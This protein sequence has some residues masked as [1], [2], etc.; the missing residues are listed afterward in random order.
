M[1]F[2][3]S[4]TLFRVAHAGCNAKKAFYLCV[5]STVFAMAF[6]IPYRSTAI[7]NNRYSAAST[8]RGSR[9]GLRMMGRMIVRVGRRWDSPPPAPQCL[10]IGLAK[11][12]RRDDRGVRRPAVCDERGAPAFAARQSTAALHVPA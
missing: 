1:G 8:A 10:G 11:A 12:F 7:H 2:A 4:M 3:W 6:Q 9:D 5:E